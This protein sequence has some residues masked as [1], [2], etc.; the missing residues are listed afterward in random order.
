MVELILALLLQL[1]ILASDGKES[2]DKKDNGG[3]TTTTT[4]FGITNTSQRDSTY[5][6]EGGT[7]T[8]ETKD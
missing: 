1:N 2:I 5:N 7:G 4:T 3:T 8:W 6:F